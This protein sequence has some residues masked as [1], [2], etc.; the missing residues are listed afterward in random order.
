MSTDSQGT[1]WR[2]NIAKN[3]NRLSRAHKRCRQTNVRQT[4]DGRAT[5]H[6]ELE[7]EF[8]FATKSMFIHIYEISFNNAY[9]MISFI[10]FFSEIWSLK[11]DCCRNRSVQA[12]LHNLRQSPFTL[13]WAPLFPFPQ[14]SP[15]PMGN[16]SSF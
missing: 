12:F 7:R 15:I 3:F 8:T 11:L 2:R 4:T 6:S 10:M 13:Q 9:Y 1:K 5:A 16:L 14:K